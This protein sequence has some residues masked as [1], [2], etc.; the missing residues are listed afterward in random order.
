MAPSIF[1]SIIIRPLIHSQ[2]ICFVDSN[3][4]L[5]PVPIHS[6]HHAS[7]IGPTLLSSLLPLAAARRSLASPPSTMSSSA[8]CRTSF[9]CT[10]RF[11]LLCHLHGPPASTTSRQRRW[12]SAAMWHVA[13][14]ATPTTDQASIDD[15]VNAIVT[16]RICYSATAC[17]SA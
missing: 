3:G 1:F 16:R 2:I 10:A 11:R 7:N 4:K 17:Y 14:S 13:R 8:R 5:P 6:A 12:T 9:T 15:V